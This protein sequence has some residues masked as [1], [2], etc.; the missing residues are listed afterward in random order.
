M[1]CIFFCEKFFP[2]GEDK[3]I[4]SFVG[5]EKSPFFRHILAILKRDD[6]VIVY[7]MKKALGHV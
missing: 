7:W 5:N 2:Y 1:V 3:R 4:I 6:D